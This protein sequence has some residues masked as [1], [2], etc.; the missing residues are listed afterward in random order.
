MRYKQIQV[1]KVRWYEHRYV[2][3]QAH[4]EIPK[5]MQ[6]HHI[7]GIKTD[8]R[9]ENLQLVTHKENKSKSDCWGKWYQYKAYKKLRPYMSR[10]KIDGKN[11]YGGYFGTACGAIMASAMYFVS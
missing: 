11:T 3:T 10:R 5:G 1:N 8:N 6:I 9:L 7:N 4:G 2:W